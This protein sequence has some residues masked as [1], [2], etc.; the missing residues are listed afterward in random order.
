MFKLPLP[1]I[2][3][4]YFKYTLLAV[5]LSFLTKY[6][7]YLVDPMHDTV[8]QF[9]M[10]IA[11]SFTVAMLVPGM[12]LTRNVEFGGFISGKLASAAGVRM[13]A[14]SG[15]L[16]AL[17]DYLYYTVINVGVLPHHLAL[18]TAKINAAPETEGINKANNV[19]GAANFFSPFMQVTF[20]MFITIAAGFFFT[21]VIAYAIRKYPP[22]EKPLF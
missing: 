17:F 11:P 3:R 16:N 4:E 15:V 8:G 22:G 2:M 1:V 13:A 18:V 14:I 9:F 20:P 7:V 21:I 5:A 12:I 6:I 10:L 19:A